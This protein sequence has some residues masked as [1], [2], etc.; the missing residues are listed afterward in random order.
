VIKSKKY[1]TADEWDANRNAKAIIIQCF[2]R[3]VQARLKV[4]QLAGIK[5]EK[6]QAYE[7]VCTQFNFREIEEGKSY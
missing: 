6:T 5:Q 2:I 3:Q 4:R 7:V 1:I